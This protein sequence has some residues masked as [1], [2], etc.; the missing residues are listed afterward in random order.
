M[1]ADL[2]DDDETVVAFAFAETQDF[3]EV[4]ERQQ[5]VAQ[6]QHRRLL[7][8]LDSVFTAA[9]GPH[10]LEHRK[11]RD[12]KAFAGRLDDEGGDDRKR[13]RNLDRKGSPG[14]G[15]GLQIDRTA[16]L[17]HIGAHHVHADATAGYAGHVRG[18][19]EAGH[20]DQIAALRLGFRRNCGLA[21][22]SVL[23]SLGPDARH[24][25]AAAVVGDLDDDMTA[26]VTGA[27][28]DRPLRRLAGGAPLGGTFD[29]VIGAV[30][31]QM[32]ERILDQL[33][34]LAVDL[35]LAAVHLE[36]DLFAQFSGKVAHDTRQ[37][38]PR[39]ADRLHAR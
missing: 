9:A 5:L 25:E 10:K 13:E 26:L 38:L 27:Q 24:V 8:P 4:D 30:A 11:L 2:R 29:P 28:P 21:G 36:F 16:D 32:R 14:A 6:T 18:G 12:G 17:L 31:D 22:K 3:L 20:E 37:F 23:D 39:I 34:Y 7:D 33:Q 1:A 19:G 15:N 35:G